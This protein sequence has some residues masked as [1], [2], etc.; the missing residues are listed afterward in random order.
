MNKNN[1]NGKRE[2]EHRLLGYTLAAREHKGTRATLMR[3]AH[4][5]TSGTAMPLVL[6]FTD[7]R[8]QERPALRGAAVIA[9]HRHL[10]HATKVGDKGYWLSFPAS[11]AEVAAAVDR[12]NGDIYDPTKPDSFDR[13]IVQAPTWDLD[14][15]AHK[16]D[17]LLSR[18]RLLDVPINYADMLHW[19]STWE[20][21]TLMERDRRAEKFMQ[22]YYRHRVNRVTPKPPKTGD[23]KKSK[24][25]SPSGEGK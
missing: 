18:A 10:P 16:F 19:L 3:G 17:E 12:E 2:W 21:G 22:D 20:L 11:L 4:D 5:T 9:K 8:W 6:G 7:A 13:I 23:D 24:A 25:D 15:A 14:E 1:G